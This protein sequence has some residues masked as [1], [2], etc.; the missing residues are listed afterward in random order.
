MLTPWAGVKQTVAAP[1][2]PQKVYTSPF[3]GRLL[4]PDSSNAARPQLTLESTAS[5]TGPVSSTDPWNKRIG[6]SAT[7]PVPRPK[8]P[9]PRLTA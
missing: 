9:L 7:A 1:W 8:A 3:L 6:T 2:L 5:Y 4:G